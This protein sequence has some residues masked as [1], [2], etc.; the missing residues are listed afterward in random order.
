MNKKKIKIGTSSHYFDVVLFNTK[1]E[2][3]K[4]TKEK[5]AVGAYVPES[6]VIYPRKK[7]GK[8]IGT[9]YLV[10]EYLGVGYIAHECFHAVLDFSSKKAKK[11]A[12][13]LESHEWEEKICWY[14]GDIV[15]QIVTWLNNKN[16]WD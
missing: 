7:I 15:R 10:K 1:T 12:D 2:F 13:L 4:H 9:I 8:H 3:K 5:T 6:Y 11:E 16:L 14:H